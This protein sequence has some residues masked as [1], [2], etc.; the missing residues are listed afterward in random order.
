MNE[1]VFIKSPKITSQ[2][3][4]WACQ[5]KHF[6]AFHVGDTSIPVTTTRKVVF[7]IQ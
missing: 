7:Q 6:Y 2:V 3:C 1:S 4:T 5:I